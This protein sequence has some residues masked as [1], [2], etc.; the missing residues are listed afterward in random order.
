MPSILAGF[1]QPLKGWVNPSVHMTFSL[2]A[3]RFGTRRHWSPQTRQSSQEC[4]VFGYR[5]G[6]H[7]ADKPRRQLAVTTAY[8]EHARRDYS[9][10][11]GA[12]VSTH[13]CMSG[14]QRSLDARGPRLSPHSAMHQMFLI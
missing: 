5:T 11:T 1:A 6:P 4:E 10:K 13:D 14:S 8:R 3:K 7:Q 9:T 12:P 2:P